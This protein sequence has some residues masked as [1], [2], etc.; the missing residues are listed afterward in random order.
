MFKRSMLVAS[1]SWRSHFLSFVIAVATSVWPI[2]SIICS[3]G[4]SMTVTYGN[5]YS[6]LVIKASGDWQW[7]RPWAKIGVAFFLDQ[8]RT[9]LRR[10]VFGPALFD[11]VL[12]L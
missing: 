12:D 8:P 3:C 2:F 11:L 4:H 7:I 9:K 10:H 6:V 5:M 1:V